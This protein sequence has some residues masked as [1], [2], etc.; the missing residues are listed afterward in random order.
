MI[1][2]KL[3]LPTLTTIPMTIL[4]GDS[5][6]TP[7]SS[8]EPIAAPHVRH[9]V[10]RNKA[11]A[12][13]DRATVNAIL[14]ADRVKHDLT[15]RLVA[16]SLSAMHDEFQTRVPVYDDVSSAGNHF[17]AIAEFPSASVPVNLNESW[18]R[19]IVIQ[20]VPCPGEWD[21]K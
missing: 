16:D 13:Y 19:R 4:H 17:R 14:D 9:Y 18:T 3:C 7:G 2:R 8:S 1:A 11:R 5:P 15:Q 6:A 10:Q 20:Y 21:Y 12:H